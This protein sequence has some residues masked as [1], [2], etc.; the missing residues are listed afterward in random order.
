MPPAERVVKILVTPLGHQDCV[1]RFLNKVSERHQILFQ[2]IPWL[3]D[4]QSAW[5]LLVQGPG[6]THTHTQM[7]SGS[8]SICKEA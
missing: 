2:R 3:S 1:R 7:S 8:G 4:V 5:L 6:P